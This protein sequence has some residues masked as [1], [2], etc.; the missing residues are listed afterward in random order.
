MRA[1]ALR[2]G[3]MLLLGALVALPPAVAARDLP[4]SLSDKAFWAL[5]VDSSEIGG[6]FP[7]DN[8]VSNEVVFQ[9]VIPTLTTTV[10]RGGVYVGVGPDQN[11]TYIAALRPKMAFIVDIRRQNMLQHLLYKALFEL[12]P[13]RTDFLSRLFSR[14]KPPNAGAGGTADALLAAIDEQAPSEALYAA[15]VSAVI[16]HLKTSRKFPLTEDDVRTIEHVYRMFFRYGPDISYA[17]MGSSGLSPY[18]SYE[19]LM[20]ETDGQ[21][22]NRAYLATDEN[23]QIVRD[24]QRKNLIVPIVG[25]FAGGKALRA[26]GSYVRERGGRVTTFYTS[27]VEQYLF[28]NNVWEAYYANVATLPLD[29]T[30]TFIRAYF[31]RQAGS[32]RMILHNGQPVMVPVPIVTPE[33]MRTMPLPSATLL[34]PIQDLLGAVR[35]GRITSYLDV[36]EFRKE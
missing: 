29:A 1:F 2:A 3:T 34:C 23:Y 20:M 36:I 25:D 5:V 21:G 28:Q 15:N 6:S 18:P 14:P 30:S 19:E 31:P 17:P 33:A 7:S 24:M 13:R 8:F 26:V 32:Q 22:V 9:T 16:D 35:D 10:A 4:G 11:F 27:N 12:S